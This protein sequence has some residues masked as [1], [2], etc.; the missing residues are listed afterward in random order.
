MQ[1]AITGRSSPSSVLRLI[2][3]HNSISRVR[4]RHPRSQIPTKV[5]KEGRK[6]GRK[7]GRK[8]GRKE[9][10]TDGRKEGRR[11]GRM[12]EWMEGR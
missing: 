5:R 2:I 8:E 9:G 12:E 11:E 1:K 4:G 10:R 7:K 3:I 6:E